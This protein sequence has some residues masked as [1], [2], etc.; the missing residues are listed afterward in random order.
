MVQSPILKL[1]A[2]S[3]AE[4][5]LGALFYNS[6]SVQE[7]PLSLTEMGWSQKATDITC[8]NTTADSIANSTIKHQYSCNEHEILLDN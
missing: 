4:A 7:L 2:A 1:V 3:V 5:E 6:Q 8:D